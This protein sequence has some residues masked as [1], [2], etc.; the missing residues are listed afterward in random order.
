MKLQPCL[1]SSGSTRHSLAVLLLTTLAVGALPALDALAGA[2]EANW[3]RRDGGVAASDTASLPRQLDQPESLRWKREL[4]PGISS[5]CVSGDRVFLTTWDADARE[6]ATV[7]LSLE[8]GSVIWRE[9]APTTTI[10]E[11]HQTG[12]PASCTPAADGERVYSFFGS[13]GLLCYSRDGDLLWK[14]ELGPFQDEFGASSSPVL[15]GDLVVL[16]EDHDVDSFLIALDRRTG[17]TVW[18]TPRPGFTRSYSTPVVWQHH[19]RTE[20]VVAGALQLT[21]YAPETGERRWTIDGLARIVNT[22]PVVDGD[23]L[24]VASWAPGGDAPG[25]EDRIGMEPWADAAKQFDTNSDGEIAKTELP[26]GPV[27]TRFFRIDLDQNGRLNQK[28]WEAHARVFE[29]ARNQ[30]MAI[31]PRADGT[32]SQSCIAWTWHRGLP[33]VP[34]PLAYRDEVYL[35]RNAGIF[36][37]LNAKTGERQRQAR[38]PGRGNYYASPVAGN[39]LVYVA[40]ERGVVSVLEA[41]P[42]WKTVSTHDFEERILATPALHKGR[43]ILRTDAAV[44]CFGQP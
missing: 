11:F 37:S 24:Y 4:P 21:G 42:Q 32:V 20:L 35:L 23:T 33:S 27:L 3:F 12:S 10:E 38:V 6:L 30:L 22:T 18:K 41:G 14:R 1:W 40:S 28:E 5:P 19:G 25:G 8:D 13:Y 26:E 44:Y 36:T 2:P 43:V 31:R 29:Q 7:A 39:G 16:N 17:R 9:V 15:V 34:S